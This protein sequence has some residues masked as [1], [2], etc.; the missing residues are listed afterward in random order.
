VGRILCVSLAV[1]VVAGCS[2][3]GPSIPTIR[4]ARTYELSGFQTL[5]HYLQHFQLF[6]HAADSSGTRSRLRLGKQP[7]KRL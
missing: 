5:A 7:T 4:A 2:S 3:S 6:Q 1:L